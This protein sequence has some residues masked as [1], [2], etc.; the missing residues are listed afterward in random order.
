M[1]RDSLT[2]LASVLA[3]R[4]QLGGRHATHCSR[5]PDPHGPAGGHPLRH[6]DRS[7]RHSVLVGSRRR[8]HRPGHPER[9]RRQLGYGSRRPR[10]REPSED[11]LHTFGR[12]E[13]PWRPGPAERSE[14]VRNAEA[15]PRRDTLPGPSHGHRRRDSPTYPGVR[16]KRRRQDRPAA[17]PTGGHRRPG[18]GGSPPQGL[19]GGGTDGVHPPVSRAQGPRLVT[20]GLD[21]TV[22]PGSGGTTSFGGAGGRLLPRMSLPSARTGRQAAA[23]GVERPSENDTQRLTCTPSR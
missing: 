17:F 8:D 23:T 5:I 11:P 21:A 20:A 14:L 3:T 4:W 22:L 10:K 9:P 2:P 6:R 15:P 19:T 7:T 18:P 16:A 13:R 12:R 1:R